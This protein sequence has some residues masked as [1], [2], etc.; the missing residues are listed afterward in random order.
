M[1]Q[2]RERWRLTWRSD[3]RF[4]LGARKRHSGSSVCGR[5]RKTQ[6]RWPARCGDWAWMPKPTRSARSERRRGDGCQHWPRSWSS[7]KT[8]G[9]NEQAAQ[10]AQRIFERL[11]LRLAFAGRQPVYDQWNR[12]IARWRSNAC[13]R[14]AKMKGSLPALED[15]IR[16][17]P[18]ATQLYESLRVLP[19]GQATRKRRTQSPRSLSSSE[20]DDADCGYRYAQALSPAKLPE[21]CEQYKVV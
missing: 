15:Q 5:L 19:V 18:T 11:A 10:V 4:T 8:D 20:P 3:E 7:I 14:P 13:R 2:Q 12:S 21:A 16:R 17:T 6:V 9:R 1:L